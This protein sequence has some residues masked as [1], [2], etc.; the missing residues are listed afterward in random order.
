MAL[1]Q[2]VNAR[3]WHSSSWRGYPFFH[4]LERIFECDT[5]HW[6]VVMVLQ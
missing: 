6:L 2:M 5:L 4:E 1:V 3:W